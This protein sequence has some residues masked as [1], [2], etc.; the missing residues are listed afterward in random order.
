MTS[1]LTGQ[2]FGWLTIVGA[3]RARGKGNRPALRVKCRCGNEFDVL[4]QNVRNGNT[5]SCG[6]YGKAKSTK[7]G[8]HGSP[9]YESWRA[10]LKRCHNRAHP[11][12]RRYGGRG[13]VVC[14]QWRS[15]FAAFLSDVGERPSLD[16][17]LDRID[18]GRGYEPGNVRWVD[19]LTQERN[20]RNTIMVTHDGRTLTVGEWSEQT[21]I[22]AIVIRRRLRSGWESGLALTKPV[23]AVYSVK[24]REHRHD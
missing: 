16:Y 19:W 22:P 12:Y 5:K 21:G 10:M 2:Q 24:D 18:N 7:H 11:A 4:A 14:E 20:R 6:C 1:S 13:I 15:S 17:T 23:R 9:T 8:Q 3:A